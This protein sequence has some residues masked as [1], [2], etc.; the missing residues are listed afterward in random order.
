MILKR[1]LITIF[2][3][4]MVMIYALPNIALFFAVA[5]V[6][7]REY[8]GLVFILLASWNIA[9]IVQYYYERSLKDKK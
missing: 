7:Y 6:A 2:S 3:L 5:T 9:K 8:V 1:S 4:L